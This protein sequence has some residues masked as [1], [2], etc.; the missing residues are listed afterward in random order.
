VI[1]ILDHHAQFNPQLGD[2]ATVVVVCLQL[3][4]W[5]IYF[6]VFRFT[7]FGQI[8]FVDRRGGELATAT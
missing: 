7:K 6:L 5:N 4:H 8:G 2:F 1:V 3:L